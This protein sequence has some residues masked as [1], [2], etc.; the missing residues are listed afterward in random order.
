MIT[1][2]DVHKTFARNRQR[3]SIA[4]GISGTFPARRSVALL[5]RNGAGKS[6]L[7]RLIA[8]TLSPDQGWIEHAGRVS[9]PIG[10]MGSFHGDLSGAQNLRFLARIYGAE[11][12]DLVAVVEE[13]ARLGPHLHLPVR[14][15]SSGMKARLSFG[16]SMAIPFDHYLVDEVTSVGDAAYR[17]ASQAL[18]KARLGSAGAIVVSHSLPLVREVCD[19]AAVLSD[20]RLTFHPNIED[21]IAHHLDI[22]RDRAA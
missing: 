14:G 4:R 1:L 7:L 10:L 5:G 11:T 3:T 20:G 18:F 21:G 2:H 17:E 13:F 12:E 6:S 15:Y 22:V 16:A 8:G 19:C 9:W